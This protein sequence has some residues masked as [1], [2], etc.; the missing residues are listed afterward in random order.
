MEMTKRPNS[1]PIVVTSRRSGSAFLRMPEVASR[2]SIQP[3]MIYHFVRLGLIDPVEWTDNPEE[4]R[5]ERHAVLLI[6]KILRLHRDLEINFAGIGVVLELLDR[7]EALER[8][9]RDL[10]QM[11]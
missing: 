3:D 9:I 8:R 10:E 5:F 4:W 7:I 2:C 6:Q 11:R 1:L